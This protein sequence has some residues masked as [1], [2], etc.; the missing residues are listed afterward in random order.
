ME[1][2]SRLGNDLVSTC[3]APRTSGF[4]VSP[5]V[6]QDQ[7][8]YILSEMVSYAGVHGTSILVALF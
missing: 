4:L 5:N 7:L 6:S 2:M 1:Q 3:M 8:R